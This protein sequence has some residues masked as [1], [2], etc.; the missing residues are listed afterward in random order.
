M[1]M[2]MFGH[3]ITCVKYY[4][5]R[6][7][8]GSISLHPWKCKWTGNQ[9]A[10]DDQQLWR[11]IRCRSCNRPGF[12]GNSARNHC[13]NYLR[14]YNSR[15]W[16]HFRHPQSCQLH[17]EDTRANIVGIWSPLPRISVCPTTSFLYLLFFESTLIWFFVYLEMTSNNC[18]LHHLC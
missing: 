1:P 4:C 7:F 6:L 10:D 3:S 5:V 16:W 18:R 9:M 11:E 13:Q 15:G 17:V 2:G 14:F 12:A 8:A